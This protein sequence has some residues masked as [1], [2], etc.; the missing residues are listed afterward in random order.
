MDLES[1][2]RDSSKPRSIFL[3]ISTFF[4]YLIQPVLATITGYL[5][6]PNDFPLPGIV[7]VI[8]GI[9]WLIGHF[10]LNKK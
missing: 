5:I 7:T 10:F 4:V 1:I 9:I 6:L 2:W 3:Q 8:G